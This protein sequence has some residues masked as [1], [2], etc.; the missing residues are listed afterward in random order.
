MLTARFIREHMA[1]CLVGIIGLSFLISGNVLGSFGV[2]ELFHDPTEGVDLSAASQIWASRPFAAQ[3][4]AAIFVSTVFI[5]F[6]AHR[7][8]RSDVDD[9]RPT[10]LNPKVLR[11]ALS[12]HAC[13]L[14]LPLPILCASLVPTAFLGDATTL[15]ALAGFAAAQIPIFIWLTLVAASRPGQ[16]DT[17][18]RLVV[19]ALLVTCLG[20][21]LNPL[22]PSD[23]FFTI[24]GWLTLAYI[25]LFY[26]DWRLLLV[27]GSVI[28]GWQL[29]AAMAMTRS[30]FQ[31]YQLPGLRVS[32]NESYYAITNHAHL[33]QPGTGRP[34]DCG[35]E[36]VAA[37]DCGRRTA[38]TLLELWRNRR[39]LQKPKIVIVAASGGAYRATFWAA[40]M[41]DV[42]AELSAPGGRLEGFTDHIRLVTGA[43]G[44][45]VGVTYFAVCHR[46]GATGQRTGAIA[47]IIER[48]VA[49]ADDGATC[50]PRKQGQG[51][52]DSLLPIADHLARRDLPDL[53][54]PR[55]GGIDRGTVLERQWRS[56]AITFDEMLALQERE[57]RPAIIFSPTIAE[58][59]TPLE[60]SS[61]RW[62]GKAEEGHPNLFDTFPEAH[63][64]LLLST[65]ARLSATYPVITPAA[66]LP[67]LPKTMHLVDA[68][69]FDNDGIDSAV[70]FLSDRDVV[71]W[72]AANSSGVV[73]LS[74]RAFP[75]DGDATAFASGSCEPLDAQVRGRTSSGDEGRF[76][77]GVREMLPQ[78]PAPLRALIEVQAQAAVIRSNVMVD[79]VKSLLAARGIAFDFVSFENATPVNMSWYL[80]RSEFNC[81]KDAARA[82][83]GTQELEKI[84]APYLRGVNNAQIE[85][86][87]G[88]GPNR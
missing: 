12:Y 75:R 13:Y 85:G 9:G 32:D 82:A 27:L 29:Y 11:S 55:T 38:R 59:G 17:I 83:N 39:N 14:A 3:F 50:I 62:V 1:Y 15:A 76:L 66:E 49:D 79:H 74:L 45:M 63:R 60:I 67:T 86:E 71:D 25:I 68:G 35:R 48:D 73:L 22:T 51:P 24:F 19:A 2:A 72:L 16:G 18:I 88:K 58:K 20:L 26:A 30:G 52:I 5:C 23:A 8:P 36:D 7:L 28:V 40:H 46:E 6:L 53:L 33:V 41:L 10:R 87:I 80:K 44:G 69:Y 43:S 65:A 61:L 64:T 21:M 78:L 70:W 34:A 37:L 47:S 77:R 84:W 57:L 81:L 31:P 4:Y 56:I 42:L 54:F